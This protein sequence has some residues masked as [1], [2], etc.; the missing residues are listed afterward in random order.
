M[1]SKLNTQALPGFMELQPNDQI[2]FNKMLTTICSVYEL[3]GFRPIETPMIERA[4]VLLAKGGGETEKQIYQFEK[5][6]TR[7]ALRFDLTVPLARYVAEHQNELVFPFKR[8]AFGKVFRGEKPQAGRFREFYQ[9]DI[10]IIGRGNLDVSYDAEIPAI[11]ATLFRQLGLEDFTIRI[12]NR[13]ILNGIFQEL[14][15][16]NVANDILRALDRV[17]KDGAKALNE[18]MD[19]LG[20]GKTQQEGVKTLL[21]LKNASAQQIFAQLK[22][23]QKNSTVLQEGITELEKVVN[24]MQLLGV[25]KE[26]YEIDL[27]I[28]RGLDYYTGTIYETRL[29]KYPEIGSVCSGGRYDNLTSYYTKEQYPGVGISIGLTRLFDQLSK[30][31]LIPSEQQTPTKVIVIPMTEDLTPSLNLAQSLRA[32]G[33]ST[34]VQSS[35]NFKKRLKY[36]IDLNIP[37]VVFI[38]E[39]EIKKNIYTVK[40]MAKKEQK[41]MKLKA[42]IKNIKSQ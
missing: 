20:L 38:G 3:F 1:P 2:A 4:E 15:L 16:S 41:A 23:L 22:L 32:E 8:Y 17:D 36:A 27:T 33:I 25:D 11:I 28:A 42:L 12:N 31:G 37:F 34:E 10:D 19:R 5:G 35:G 29:N 9:C 6:D 26:D 21:A 14:E 18:E 40:D 24:D 7:L 13:K 39:E 30:R